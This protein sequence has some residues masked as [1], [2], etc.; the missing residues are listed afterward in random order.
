[1]AKSHV[2]LLLAH[3][4]PLQIPGK[5][6]EY[7]GLGS[8]ILAILDD[9]ATS[10]LLKNYGKAALVRGND[11]YSLK[12][13]IMEFYQNHANVHDKESQTMINPYER[14]FLTKRLAEVLSSAYDTI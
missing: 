9:G 7:I 14:R 13:A 5:V 11:I 4:Q 1:M 3:K 10:D 6:F 8:N 12:E 2:L